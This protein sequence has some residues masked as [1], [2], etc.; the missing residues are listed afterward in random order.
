MKVPFLLATTLVV[1]VRTTGVSGFEKTG[2]CIQKQ[3]PSV[4]PSKVYTVGEFKW[5]GG[6]M[7]PFTKSMSGFGLSL[8]TGYPSSTAVSQAA[9]CAI[10]ST[11]DSM[12]PPFVRSPA[13]QKQVISNMY[14][15]RAAFPVF[16][17]VP[18]PPEESASWDKFLDRYS[19]CDVI[20]VGV[21]EK[22]QP[23]EIIEGL[24]HAVTTVGLHY[25]YPKEW[26]IGK[27]S[28]LYKSMQKAISKGIFN[29]QA[30]Q[31]ITDDGIKTRVMLQEY[32]YRVIASAWGLISSDTSQEWT[33]SSPSEMKSKL[34]DAWTLYDTTVANIMS[35]PSDSAVQSLKAFSAGKKEPQ[36]VCPKSRNSDSTTLSPTP[37]PTSSS[38]TKAPTES[39]N[40]GG[41]DA[42]SDTLT[43]SPT[44]ASPAS[45]LTPSTF[46]GAAALATTAA[47]LSFSLPSSQC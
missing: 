35:R 23:M 11:L 40:A 36:P 31:K 18:K 14:K 13:K 29:I 20:Y 44:A 17:G 15:Y 27:S 26:G 24:L 25:A 38:P 41:K 28:D 34:P 16:Q 12:F 42:Q 10:L 22:A 1:L 46:L 43:S 21:D 6:V 37:S 33:I 47:A 2:G 19:V 9:L 45:N 30:Y 4:V 8:F 3:Y 32:G 39:T 5:I 7:K